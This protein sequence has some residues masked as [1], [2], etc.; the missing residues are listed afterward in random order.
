MVRLGSEI[1]PQNRFSAVRSEPDFEHGEDATADPRVEYIP[2]AS[3]SVVA[4]NRSPDV[5]FRF[6]VNPYRGCLHGCSYCFARP[7]HEFLGYS[8]G[9]D[10]E[11]KIVVKHEAPALLRE[12]LS[13]P[14]WKCE[15]IAFSG[16]TDCYQPAERKLRLTRQCLEVCAEFRQPVSV[17]TKNAL[18]ARDLDLLADMAKDRLAEVSVSVTTLDA[19]LAREMEPKTSTPEARLR[20]M[21]QLADAG[22]PVRVMVA[23][24]IPGLTDHEIPQ[25]LKAASDT[26]AEDAHY[27]L[28]RLPLSVE[29]V[30][31]EWLHR[32]QPLK[33][34]K[35]ESLVRR[36]RDG[37]LYQSKW[38]ERQLGT[39]LVAEQIGKLFETFARRLGL[40]AG[41][42]PLDCSLFRPPKQK[43]GQLTLF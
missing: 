34:K 2:D 39:G 21:K 9:L 14:S 29:P 1:N 13:R 36:T 19:E 7:G 35:V 11:T 3:R 24:V 8:G 31:L 41:L 38:R 6:G 18:V 33:A 26:G 22:V 12:F 23:P 16:V 37:K 42:P 40:D 30:F 17:I 20:A 32:A 10:F 27:V 28:L 4:E 25:I 15:P 43:A 5:G